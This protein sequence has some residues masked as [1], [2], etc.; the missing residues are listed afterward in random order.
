MGNKQKGLQ[1]DRE[2]SSVRF[3]QGLPSASCPQE[4][5]SVTAVMCV[6]L[7]RLRNLLRV[8]G[9]VKVPRAACLLEIHHGTVW[10]QSPLAHVPG[11]EHA[12]IHVVR[13]TRVEVL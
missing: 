5:H 13:I 6:D 4:C 1:H 8:Q 3:L 11:I 2:G 10:A 7:G 12:K 9:C